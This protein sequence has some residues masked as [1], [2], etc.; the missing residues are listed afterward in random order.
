MASIFYKNIRGF[1]GSAFIPPTQSAPNI[2][3]PYLL[4]N[5]DSNL[6]YKAYKAKIVYLDNGPSPDFTIGYG[7]SFTYLDDSNNYDNLEDI[8]S[9]IFNN[10]NKYYYIY[11]E[12]VI[13]KT[14]L[15]S[16]VENYKLI[17]IFNNDDLV[18]YDSN[19]HS[20]PIPST[21]YNNKIILLEEGHIELDVSNVSES[22]L[23]LRF[24]LET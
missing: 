22:H 18:P 7:R 20:Q 8:A 14:T 19:D 9:N 11:F 13:D 15:P 5:N 17:K 2:N 24:V 21:A 4:V 12:F 3:T 23:S 16:A 10:Q 1:I 6:T